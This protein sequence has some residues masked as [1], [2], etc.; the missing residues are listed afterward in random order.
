MKT[1]AIY[2]VK[3]GVGKTAAAVNLAYLAAES[4]LHTLLWDLDPQGAAT[5]YLHG[6]GAKAPDK[7]IWRG[8]APIG[9]RIVETPHHELLHL[10]PADL[11]ARHLDVWLR[12]DNNSH[13]TLKNL[14][15]PLSE[16]YSLLV[17]DCP[18][19]LSHVADNIFA[20]V[21]RILVPTVP[22]HL[23]LRALMTLIDYFK[24]N[25]LPRT[26]L[27]P[28]WSMA[29]R[30]RLLHKG[31]IE[32]PPKAMKDVCQAVI[33]YASSIERMGETRAP[34]VIS[35]PSSDASECYRAL[36]AENANYL[37]RG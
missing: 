14:I 31:L 10:I 17:L 3:G 35:E 1:L 32:Q 37:R 18:P 36:W 23:S 20:A 16:Q 4:G 19:S 24:A 7:A 9:K 28:F 5:W 12:K 8:T 22:T 21:D 11:E 15:E 6:D 33:P 34:V 13:D 29:D 30:R 26:R 2:N 25:E 27:R